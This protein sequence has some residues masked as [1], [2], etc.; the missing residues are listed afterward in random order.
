MDRSDIV[1]VRN[2]LLVNV[3]HVLTRYTVRSDIKLVNINNDIDAVEREFSTPPNKSMHRTFKYRK[4]CH[5]KHHLGADI[6][7]RGY[8]RCIIDRMCSNNIYFPDRP[9]C[10]EHYRNS[11][12]T[13]YHCF[14]NT[15]IYIIIKLEN[16]RVDKMSMDYLCNFEKEG[17]IDKE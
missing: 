5:I 2:K 12:I 14:S 13:L 16:K 6:K 3:I 10:I 9:P 11:T 17:S 8:I 7:G 4:H 15:K 1:K